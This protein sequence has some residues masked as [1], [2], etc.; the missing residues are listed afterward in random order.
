VKE[1]GTV[2]TLMLRGTPISKGEFDP[3]QPSGVRVEVTSKTMPAG[4]LEHS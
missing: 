4:A 2:L 1:P 3:A